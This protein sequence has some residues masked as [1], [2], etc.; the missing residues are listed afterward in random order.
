MFIH[1][2]ALNNTWSSNVPSNG[3]FLGWESKNLSNGWKCLLILV[4]S[5][6]I[7][8]TP[9]KLKN[10]PGRGRSRTCYLICNAN[11][12][13]CHLN[14]GIKS[15]SLMKIHPLW[16]YRFCSCLFCPFFGSLHAELYKTGGF[17]SASNDYFNQALKV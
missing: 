3:L 5:K 6:N 4:T 14:Y 12:K 7:I 11:Q 1:N 9:G 15:L 10:M 17:L 16:K 13:V 8:L 2:L